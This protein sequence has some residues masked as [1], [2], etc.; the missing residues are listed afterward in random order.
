MSSGKVSKKPSILIVDD[1]KNQR[2]LLSKFFEKQGYK[3]F[4]ASTATEA[5]EIFRKQ[6]FDSAIIDLKL[7]D[8]DGIELLRRLRS[9]DPDLGAV[10]L[11]AYGTISAAAEG[12]KSGAAEFMEKPVDLANL[13][14]V[15]ESIIE[16]R[17]IIAENK[18]LKEISSA[19]IPADIVAESPQMKEILSIVARVAPT[20]ATVLITGE[21]GTGKELIARLIHQ[22][23][24]RA[25][26]T[27]VPINCAAI[28]ETLIE[29][30]LFG[31]EP[32]AFTGARK[33]QI[34]KLE[35]ADG[36][37][38]FLDEIGDLPLLV[39]A[40]ILRFLEDGQFFRLGGTQPVKTDVR[41][42]SATNR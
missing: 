24:K 21:S 10:I 39:Q 29:S 35:L 5:E 11:T 3:T 41:V 40:K 4:T 38:I 26:R 34:G 20:D 15:I 6:G 1:E 42:I 22:N 33:R 16:K 31:Y 18:L 7:P 23:S 36:G 25:Q 27:F 37:T 9:I 14:K 19:N 13:A 32:G 12:I 8:F 17:Q 28:P 2:E 30:E